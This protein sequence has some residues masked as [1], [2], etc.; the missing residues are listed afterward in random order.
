MENKRNPLSYIHEQLCFFEEINPKTALYN[1]PLAIL[2]TGK[3][4]ID[5]LTKSLL[6][7]I[8]HHESL[9]MTIIKDV[10]W[11]FQIK[12]P[13]KKINL[14]EEKVDTIVELF[15]KMKQEAK[16]PFSFE[17][18]QLFRCK[19]WYFEENLSYLQLTIHHCIADGYSINIIVK[20][21]LKI[22]EGLMLNTRF[23]LENKKME[24]RDFVTA[25]REKFKSLK[26]PTIEYNTDCGIINDKERPL[27]RTFNGKHKN[28]FLSLEIFSNLTKLA[29][30]CKT[31]LYHVI[32]CALQALLY[33]YNKAEQITIG[34]LFANRELETKNTIGYFSNTLVLNS[35]FSD[36][37][38]F[39]ELILKNKD[40]FL[41]LVENRNLPF[42]QLVK[43]TNVNRDPSRNPIFNILVAK[44]ENFEVYSEK[45]DVKFE[46]LLVDYD[47][48][49]FDLTVFI[50]ENERKICFQYNTDLYSDKMI[51]LIIKNFEDLLVQFSQNSNL[52]ISDVCFSNLL[53]TQGEKIDYDLKKT[54]KDYLE[55]QIKKT[56]SKIAVDSPHE[57]VK[58]TYKQ[59]HEK[60]N[61]LARYISRQ[62]IQKGQ[63]VGVFMNRSIDMIVSI[64]GIIKMGGVY[65][66]IDPEYPQ[67]RIDF[68]R[69]DAQ[70]NLIISDI[71]SIEDKLCNYS[72]EYLKTNT[73][74][75]RWCCCW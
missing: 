30:N 29:Y 21:L 61:Q 66:P 74:N 71:K 5:I 20:E 24:Y 58:L 38:T 10:M 49:K 1:I 44:E 47:K 32:L 59:L 34:I 17:G 11:Y 4:D 70:I 60:S 14:R 40:N 75:L 19:F 15:K 68:I 65:V 18:G 43:M 53:G 57:N 33:R 54:L 46:S 69:K 52:Q 37:L 62:G 16:I 7:L 3:V 72:K 55:Q 36:Y 35:R 26:R 28:Y 51:D 12:A 31:N 8:N 64:L 48:A 39:N 73:K 22:Y 67:E 13:I 56:P 9:R 23:Q 6:I 50:N 63:F 2:I 25:E 45:L 41:E 27:F 42:S